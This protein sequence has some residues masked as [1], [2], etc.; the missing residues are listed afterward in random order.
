LIALIYAHPHP[1]RSRANRLLLEAARGVP[2]VTVRSL[3]DSYPD[4]EIDVA[5]ERKLLLES[6]LI[7]WQHPLMWYSAPALQKLWFD[8][9][10]ANGWATGEGGTALVGKTCLWVTTT[11]A[12][13][14]GY[15]AEGVHRFPFAAFVPVMEMTARYCGMH[16]LPPLVVHGAHQI[17]DAVLQQHAA[18]YRQRLLSFSAEAANG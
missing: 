3:Y 7:V 15:T 18:Q 2:A 11:G 9:V 8:T 12:A 13:S 10:L 4:F 5:A 1:A 16:W 6:E 14:A 17:D